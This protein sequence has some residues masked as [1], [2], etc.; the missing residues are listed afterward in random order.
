MSRNRRAFALAL[1]LILGSADAIA[2][3]APAPA[4]LVVQWPDP[5]LQWNAVMLATVGGKNAVEQQRIAA[6]AHLAVFEAVNAVTRDY[7]PYLGSVAATPD[8]SAEAA[9]IAAAHGVLLQYVPEQVATLDA[10]RAS[11]LAQNSGRAVEGR[12][13]RGSARPQRPR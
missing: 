12:G 4:E 10:A 1:T 9:A 7:E 6:I 8:A 5:V 2:Q 3:Q 11:S 13:H